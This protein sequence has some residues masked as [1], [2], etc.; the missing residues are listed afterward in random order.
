MKEAVLI[1]PAGFNA[2]AFAD[3]QSSPELRIQNASE[4]TDV[5]NMIEVAQEAYEIYS[6]NILRSS[7]WDLY[8]DEFPDDFIETPAPLVSVGGLYYLDAAGVEQTWAASNYVVDTTSRLI[9]KISRAFGIAWP[10][11]YGQ[12]NAVRVRFTAGYASAAA[13]P[14]IIKRGLIARIQEI[15]DGDDRSKM[16]ESMWRA[17]R[18]VP[19]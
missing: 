2:F 6:G 9:G 18:R 14:E 12:K 3:I 19:V 17:Y 16:Y 5:E 11:V 4:E 13:I 15:Y 10:A 1:T 7:V 8:L